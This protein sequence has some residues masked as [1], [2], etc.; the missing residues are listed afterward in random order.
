[1]TECIGVTS[2]RDKEHIPG[3][4][5]RVAPNMEIKIIDLKSGK[6]LGKNQ[7]GEICVRGPT[8][9]LG[10]LNNPKA[11]NETIDS[12]GWL[13]TGDVGQFDYNERL[14]ITDRIKELIKFRTWSV[15]PT[16]IE[17][18]LLRHKAI[19]EVAVIGV[20]HKEDYEV[21]KAFIKCDSNYNVSEE[22]ILKFVS[23]LQL[24]V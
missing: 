20:P 21:P 4:C 1:M 24:F 9:F 3:N 14:F 12:E 16:E 10:Y 2:N 13:H 22:E 8:V 7:S 5:G 17:D 6:S 11:T 15:W 18:F 19:K 23:G